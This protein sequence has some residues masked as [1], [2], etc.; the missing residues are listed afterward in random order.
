MN[1]LRIVVAVLALLSAAQAHAAYSCNVTVTAIF[2][3]YDPNSA[4]QNDTAGT[5][6]INCTRAAT[7]A[8]T[9]AWRMGVNNGLNAGGGFNRVV[10]TGAQRYNYDTYRLQP[11]TAANIWANGATTRFTGTLSF[12]T[13]L[14]ASATSPFYIV[15]AGSQPVQPAGTYTDTVTVTLQ[16]S[17]GT[18]LDTATMSVTVRTDNQC[19]ISSPPGNVTFTY[20][21]FQASAATASTTYNVRCTT[22]LP[23]TM[24]LDS[25]SGTLLG[26]PYTL[27][28]SPSASGTGTGASQTYTIN[29]TI[30]AGQAGTCA[31]AACSG[32][33]VRTLTLTW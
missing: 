12:G 13:G 17:T 8:N 14:T 25:F 32:S 31:T 19:Q 7:D 18:N 15:M 26:L 3:V 4:V 9:L 27:A 33:Q 30:A 16:T 24:A 2:V 22:A 6:T 5:Y 20:T 28:I 1:A 11:Y 21:S 29:G 10:R 23:Y